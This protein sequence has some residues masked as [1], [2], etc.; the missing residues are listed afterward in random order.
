MHSSMNNYLFGP[1][2][3]EY[4]AYFYILSVI[5]FSFM[6]FSLMSFLYLLTLGSKKMDAKLATT[7]FL[8]S[9]AY[10]VLYFQS[11]LLHSICLGSND[12]TPTCNKD[13]HMMH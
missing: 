13:K 8:G 2:K 7:I 4:C 9:L 10:G 11:R 3:V 1:L 5:Q 6:I 12:G